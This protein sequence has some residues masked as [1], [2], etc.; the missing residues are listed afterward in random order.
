MN[1]ARILESLAPAALLVSLAPAAAAAAVQAEAEALTPWRIATMKGVSSAEISPD[2]RFVAYVLK[3]QREPRDEEDGSAR[4]QLHVLDFESGRTR[5][6]ITADSGV[7]S[8]H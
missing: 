1:T 8:V 6:F 2:G 3:V 4:S 7:S 5:A